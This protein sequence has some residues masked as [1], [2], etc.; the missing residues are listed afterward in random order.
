MENPDD[1]A[2]G[3]QVGMVVTVK[4][5][6][7]DSTHAK[8][9]SVTY[10]DNLEGPIAAFDNAGKSMTVLGQKITFDSA[11][12]FDD[13]PTKGTSSVALGQMVEVSGLTDASGTIKATRIERQ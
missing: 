1:S 11:T 10:F 2:S 6:F 4:G 7:S 5:T 9:T 8:A 12:V 3:L 13:F